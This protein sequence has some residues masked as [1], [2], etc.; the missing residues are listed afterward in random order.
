M[1][2]TRPMSAVEMMNI[3]SLKKGPVYK[4]GK[5]FG[6]YLEVWSILTYVV[7]SSQ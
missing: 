4:R 2:H 5:S 3:V 7:S 1:I 6:K